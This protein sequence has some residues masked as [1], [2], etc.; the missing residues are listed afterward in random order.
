MFTARSLLLNDE[1]AMFDAHM[2]L[3]EVKPAAATESAVGVS[4]YFD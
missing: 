4:N 1:R 2:E 3:F